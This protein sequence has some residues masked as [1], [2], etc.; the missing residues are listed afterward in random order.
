MGDLAGH[1][2]PGPAGPPSPLSLSPQEIDEY[3]TQAR[4]KSYETMMRVGKRGLNLAANAAVTAAAKV[5]WGQSR[6]PGLPV[7]HLVPLAS[8]LCIHHVLKAMKVWGLVRLALPVL[9]LTPTSRGTSTLQATVASS[10][11]RESRAPVCQGC[12]G[13][14]RGHWQSS[15]SPTVTSLSTPPLP[16]VLL[17]RGGDPRARGCCQRSC[18][19]SACRT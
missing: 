17:A 4:D 19:A 5:R 1:W 14:G 2:P 11:Q 3:I 12:Q 10:V 9:P 8:P 15:E 6:S 18:E 7:T 16:P 13:T